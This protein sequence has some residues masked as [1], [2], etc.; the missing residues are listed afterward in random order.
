MG[1]FVT[2]REGHTHRE[3]RTIPSKKINSP[4]GTRGS[5]ISHGGRSP[6]LTPSTPSG[7]AGLGSG[8]EM[9]D[10]PGL[11]PCGEGSQGRQCFLHSSKVGFGCSVRVAM[12]GR[13]TV[14]VL[15]PFVRRYQGRESHYPLPK[16][17]KCTLG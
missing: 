13:F 10:T 4:A 6:R 5:A 3:L 1:I 8:E 7:L 15:N 9:S 14:P 11:V 16:Q 12:R 17:S 2:G